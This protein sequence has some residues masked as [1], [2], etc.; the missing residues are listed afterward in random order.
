MSI[1]SSNSI[2]ID[3]AH[4]VLKYI[5]ILK[6]ILILPLEDINVIYNDLISYKPKH[7]TFNYYHI[8]VSELRQK[9]PNHYNKF[10]FV[11]NKLSFE[12]P[13]VGTSILLL[14][15]LT[16][17][18]ILTNGSI[19][20]KA[21]MLFSWYNHNQSGLMDEAE[22]QYFII[23]ACDSLK[24]LR[25][26]GYIDITIEEAS[27]MALE[28][29]VKYQNNEITFVPGLKL[30]DFI[31]WIMANKE[32][33]ALFRFSII[34]NRLIETLVLIESRTNGLV[35]IMNTKK[36]YKYDALPVPNPEAI[37]CLTIQSDIPIYIV[38]RSQTITSICIPWRLSDCQTIKE[39]YIKYDKLVPYIEKHFTIP[40]TILN[41]NIEIY[42]TNTD[43]KLKC[44]QK[45]MY[46]TSY[47]KH[48]IEDSI[49]S[50]KFDIPFQR[51]DVLNLD[52]SSLYNLTLYTNTIQY[53]T[54]Q[55]ETLP[56]HSLHSATT[57]TTTTTNT[58]NTNTKQ[59]LPLAVAVAEQVKLSST[60]SILPACIS[61][62][63]A[64]MFINTTPPL[65]DS[66][67]IVF[68]GTICPMNQVYL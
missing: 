41:R 3:K 64:E 55:V 51:I 28:A 15:L 14:D 2:C 34:L 12:K 38:Y 19:E 67:I 31:K 13:L 65:R 17:L 21:R 36:V 54:I 52:H 26:I 57:T 63:E 62:I 27:Y 44:C 10:L 25:L 58:I 66:N 32:C 60:I 4:N 46:L 6:P 5:D 49:D 43:P 35:D 11:I 68:T 47:Q 39:I 8:L 18:C 9:I 33:N 61:V 24:K 56:M 40:E 20:D 30:K 1:N 29:R 22:H 42:K 48:V 53:R 7:I 50:R 45:L 37:K 23:R 59:S 16:I